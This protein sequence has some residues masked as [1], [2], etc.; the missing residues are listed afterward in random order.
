MSQP[1]KSTQPQLQLQLQQMVPQPTDGSQDNA[2][3]GP[4]Q[5]EPPAAMTMEPKLG[6]RGGGI[7]GDWY[8]HDLSWDLLCRR[9]ALEPG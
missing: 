6:L 4:K 8:V 3:L 2:Y 1:L 5:P 7:V 9:Y